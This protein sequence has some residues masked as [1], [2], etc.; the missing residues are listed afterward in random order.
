MKRIWRFVKWFVSKCGWFEA[1]MFITSFSLAAGL[2]AGEGPTRNVF[3]GIAI[4]V[5]AL[6]M[7]AFMAWGARNIWRDFVK[8]DERVFDILKKE[9]IDGQ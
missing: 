7:L 4:A 9:K 8:H 6:A 2:T 3:W 1:V 5:N